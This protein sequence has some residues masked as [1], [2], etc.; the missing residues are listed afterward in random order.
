MTNLKVR[1]FSF[2]ISLPFLLFVVFFRKCV[3]FNFF[4]LAF[5][6]APFLAV[7]CGVEYFSFY[8]G[9]IKKYS[10]FVVIALVLLSVGGIGNINQKFPH[11]VNVFGLNYFTYS[12]VIIFAVLFIFF[13][14]R[15]V[16]QK[17]KCAMIRIYFSLASSDG[18]VCTLRLG[19]R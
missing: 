10:G 6:F 14:E 17:L 12:F 19:T 9:D 13:I 2:F 18:V 16:F 15:I 7:F 3:F 8:R 5:L 11:L 4:Y 1:F